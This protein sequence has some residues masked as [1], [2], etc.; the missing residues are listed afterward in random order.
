MRLSRILGVLAAAA[1]VPLATGCAGVSYR[2]EPTTSATR[3]ATIENFSDEPIAPE[4]VD[5]LLEEVAGILKVALDPSKPKVRILVVSPT[6]I[7]DLYRSVAA[8]AVH[9][10]RAA[11]LYFPGASLILVPHY[12]RMLLG[13]ELAHYL[14]DHYLKSVPRRDWEKIAHHVEDRLPARPP[15]A[16]RT[17]AP[18]ALVTLGRIPRAAE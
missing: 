11:A 8:T 15:A 18:D 17:V 1:L 7:A 16:K 3:Y 13:H 2:A 10:A 12:D 14:T 4:Q 9:G 5:G 6:R